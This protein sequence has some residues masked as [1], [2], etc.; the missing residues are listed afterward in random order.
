M[1]ASEIETAFFGRVK[2]FS[3]R[4]I[5]LNTAMPPT[6][7]SHSNSP[8]TSNAPSGH[9]RSRAKP[10]PLD[11]IVI[12]SDDE[13]QTSSS[14][15]LSKASTS[16]RRPA[17]KLACSTQRRRNK[18]QPTV[19][20]RETGVSRVATLAD[21]NSGVFGDPKT[22]QFGTP[23]PNWTDPKDLYQE[24]LDHP[25]IFSGNTPEQK[26]AR[27]AEAR[28]MLNRMNPRSINVRCNVLFFCRDP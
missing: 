8:K 15:P 24:I 20:E 18:G 1:M 10:L 14:L 22:W 7:T 2:R 27:L 23:E 16:I 5:R 11:V 28:E 17:A 26:E 9:R 19:V 3:T 6:R 13:E 21:I 25:T 12:S 4:S